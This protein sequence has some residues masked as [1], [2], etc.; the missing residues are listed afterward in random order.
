MEE[1]FEVGLINGSI[2]SIPIEKFETILEQ[3]KKGI[4]KIF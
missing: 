4:C 3:M 2:D 1:R